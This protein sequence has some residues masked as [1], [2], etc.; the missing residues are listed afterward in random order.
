MKLVLQQDD[1]APDSWQSFAARFKDLMGLSVEAFKKVSLR[2]SV[3]EG[4]GLRWTRGDFTL[5][6]HCEDP[7]YGLY[8]NGKDMK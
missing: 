5:E 4:R 8:D 3:D 1:C 6:F 2:E 7:Y